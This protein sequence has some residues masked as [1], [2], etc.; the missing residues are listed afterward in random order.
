MHITYRIKKVQIQLTVRQNSFKEDGQLL[1]DILVVQG[2]VPNLVL[3]QLLTLRQSTMASL[4][5]NTP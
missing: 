3:K 5:H 1:K 2:T 4:S